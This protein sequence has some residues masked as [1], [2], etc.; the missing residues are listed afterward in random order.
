M[1]DSIVDTLKMIPIKELA[2]SGRAVG[3]SFK[4]RRRTCR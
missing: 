2:V 4:A 1:I 3:L